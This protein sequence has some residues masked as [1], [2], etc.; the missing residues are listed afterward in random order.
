MGIHISTYYKS[1]SFLTFQRGK[2][3][4][5]ADKDFWVIKTS[6]AWLKNTKT[7][8]KSFVRLKDITEKPLK[9]TWKLYHIRISR[10]IM[11]EQN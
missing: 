11:N 5:K 10:K 8:S 7:F 1:L 4:E 9:G 6:S 3:K 2:W